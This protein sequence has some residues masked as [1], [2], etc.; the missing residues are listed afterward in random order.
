MQQ[1]AGE[2]A[3]RRRARAGLDGLRVLDA[4]L[5]QVHVHVDEARRDDRAGRVETSA[6]PDRQIPCRSLSMRP[7]RIRTSATPSPPDAGSITRPPVIN[8]ELHSAPCQNPLQ[9]GHPH[10]DA[11][12]HLIQNHR[13]L[14]VRHF[15]TQFAA[16]IDRP[17]MHH[18]RIR[19]GVRQMFQPQTVKTEVFA[20]RHGRFMLPL[21][22]H[23]Q[24]H[25]DVGVADR[26]GHVV[27][28]TNARRESLQ[29]PR[30]QRRR[31]AQHD[32]GAELRKQMNVGSRHAAVRNVA[33]DGHAQTFELGRL[34]ENRARVEQRLRRML[35]RAVARH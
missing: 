26:L 11:V 6:S 18:D 23:A 8:S 14:A 27:G 21:Q 16:A 35:V 4:G 2:S 29:F 13:P 3:G 10:R 9:H 1:M 22:L 20:R 25:D 28:Q 19:L 31:P 12:L 17:R 33:D 30:Q 24:H 32:F 34:I 5:A 7:S 15:R